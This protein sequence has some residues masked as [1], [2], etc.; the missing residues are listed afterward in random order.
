MPKVITFTSE[1]TIF[2]TIAQLQDLDKKVNDFIQQNSV[3]KVYSISDT[4]TADETGTTIGI[5]RVL[6]YD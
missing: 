3:E 6:A 5:I 1:L 4:T 2:K